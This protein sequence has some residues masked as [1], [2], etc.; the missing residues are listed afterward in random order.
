MKTTRRDF[1][2]TVGQG[3]LMAGV[4]AHLAVDM[5]LA[6]ARA[7]DVPEPLNFGS[8][9]SLVVLMQETPIQKLLPTLVDRIHRAR[10]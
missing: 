2:S 6:K 10:N 3:M 7:A 9:E 5:G 8:L 4:R 1:L